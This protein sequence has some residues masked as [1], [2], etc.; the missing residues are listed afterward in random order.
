MLF[1]SHNLDAVSSLTA[2]C[3]LLEK[4]SKKTFEETS[5]ALGVYRASYL[6][7]EQEYLAK[8][9][10]KKQG[11]ATIE[12]VKV[13]TSDGAGLQQHGA[14]LIFEVELSARR[15]LSQPSVA[16]QVISENGT[17]VTHF[18]NHSFG[19]E[20]LTKPNHWKM[21]CSVSGALL[22][23]GK[24]YLRVYYSENG[25]HDVLTHV[26]MVCGFQVEMDRKPRNCPW[27]EGVSIYL[28]EFNWDKIND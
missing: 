27:H 1:V 23:K 22:Y 8:D 3:L 6:P 2:K 13:I 26:D 7:K 25:G 16:I 4:G 19:D 28:Q 5:K 14:P 11:D 12:R 18:W 9:G 10:P 24:Y 15:P 21:R 20:Y 17:P